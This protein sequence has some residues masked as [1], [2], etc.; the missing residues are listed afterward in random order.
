[1]TALRG[2]ISAQHVAE[3]VAVAGPPRRRQRL[4]LVCDLAGELVVVGVLLLELDQEGDQLGRRLRA[5]A[6][7][8]EQQLVLEP[9]MARHAAPGG[10]AIVIHKADALGDILAAFDNRFGALRILPIHARASGPAIRVIVSGIKG[11]RAP[12]SLLPGFVLHDEGHGFTL[13]AQS[14]LRQGAGLELDATM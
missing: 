9:R 3:H 4:Q 5:A 10:T 7:Q 14:V 6:E 12:L 8:R 1:M 13:A 11:S 2:E